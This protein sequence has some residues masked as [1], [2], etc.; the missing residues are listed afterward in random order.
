MQVRIVCF[1]DELPALFFQLDEKYGEAMQLVGD[2][3]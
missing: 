3:T 1:V 2:L